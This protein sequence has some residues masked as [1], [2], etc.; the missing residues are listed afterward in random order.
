MKTILHAK[1]LSGKSLKI[2]FIIMLLIGNVGILSFENSYSDV[3]DDGFE[4]FNDQAINI[5]PETTGTKIQ[6][7]LLTE[8]F[9]SKFYSYDNCQHRLG[10]HP[11]TLTIISETFS[12]INLRNSSFLIAELSTST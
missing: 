5:L 12:E 7:K 9:A 10:F 6:L 4:W 3:S 2:L 8:S 11:K 1:E